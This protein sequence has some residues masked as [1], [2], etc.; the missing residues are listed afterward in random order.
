MNQ[1]LDNEEIIRERRRQKMRE[2]QRQ[3]Q[4]QMQMRKAIRTYAPLVGGFLIL[5]IIIFIGYKIFRKTFG[6]DQYKENKTEIEQTDNNVA[7]EEK[8][9]VLTKP[10]KRQNFQQK[11]KRRRFIMQRL[12]RIRCSRARMSSVSMR[13]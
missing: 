2:M 6:L 4:K 13:F 9:T 11:T 12:Q 8:M 7:D 1:Q 3:K 10:V 5:C